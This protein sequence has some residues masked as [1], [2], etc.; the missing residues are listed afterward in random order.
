MLPG[1][2][3]SGGNEGIVEKARKTAVLSHFVVVKSMEMI[4]NKLV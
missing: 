1:V 3:K 4:Y 2:D